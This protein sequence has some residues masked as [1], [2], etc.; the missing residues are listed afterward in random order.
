MLEPPDIE[1]T[2]SE[3]WNKPN[4]KPVELLGIV[5]YAIESI[6]IVTRPNFCSS[7]I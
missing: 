6:L 1:W 4:M 2:S 5:S 3:E 7:Q